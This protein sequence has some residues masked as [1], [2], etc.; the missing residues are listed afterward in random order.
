MVV[1]RVGD[2]GFSCWPGAELVDRYTSGNS[3]SY[4][5]VIDWIWALAVG[6]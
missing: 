3:E 6:S 2:T 1:R 4:R 5:L